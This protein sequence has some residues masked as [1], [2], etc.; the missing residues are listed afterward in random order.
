MNN[1][2]T[3]DDKFVDEYIFNHR[4]NLSK[5]TVGG[6]DWR[7]ADIVAPAFKEILEIAT[8]E[9]ILEIGFNVGGSALMF[10]SINPNLRYDSVDIIESKK[11]IDFLKNT[12]NGFRFFHVSSDKLIPYIFWS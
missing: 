9:R 1:L 4:N 11:S 3:I 12:F 6:T 2:A 10:L 8:P 5:P 7:F